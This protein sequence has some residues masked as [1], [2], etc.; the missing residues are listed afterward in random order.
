MEQTARQKALLRSGNFLP[1]GDLVYGCPFNVKNLVLIVFTCLL[2]S[3]SFV[4]TQEN[5]T[6]AYAATTVEAGHTCTWHRVV[7]GDTLGDIA[8]SYRSTIWDLARINHVRNVNLIFVGQVL[9]IDYPMNS[10]GFSTDGMLPNGSV[11]WYAYNALEWSNSAQVSTQIRQAAARYGLSAGL[12]LAI[13]W[14]ESG[15]N[16]H[17][18]SRDGGIGVMQIMPYTA[19]G[20]DRQT[21]MSYNPYKLSDNIELG[22]IYLRSLM[23]GFHGN[24][25]EVISAYNEGGWSVL[26]RGIFNWKYVN[27]V[28]A[29]MYW[30]DPL[31]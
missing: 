20:L 9:C 24:L 8:F 7:P 25:N 3:G 6:T 1:S 14:Q 21:G 4:M 10:R 27:S 26:H 18:I 31:H 17:I 12:L 23:N 5:A 15:W 30:T 16:Q 11:R 22:A 2:F 28:R 19:S 13:A 29:L